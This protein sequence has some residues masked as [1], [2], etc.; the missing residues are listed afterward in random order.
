MDREQYD[1]DVYTNQIINDMMIKVRDIEEKQRILKDRLLLIG[2]NL[3][4]TKEKYND[5]ILQLKKEIEIIKQQMERL[6]SFSET[7]SG[8]FSEFARKEDLDILRKQARMF[9]PM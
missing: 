8:E 3:I 7:I 2:Q 6:I 9:Q 4:E 5:S 1:Y